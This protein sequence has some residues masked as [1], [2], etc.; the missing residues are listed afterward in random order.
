MAAG[1]ARRLLKVTTETGILKRLLTM[2]LVAMFSQTHPGTFMTV[3]YGKLLHNRSPGRKFCEAK[4]GNT[5]D[6]SRCQ[7]ASSS[8][9]AS[10]DRAPGLLSAHSNTTI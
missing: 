1:M 10:S 2:A 5:G 6:L 8:L 3:S 4:A 9:K 7:P